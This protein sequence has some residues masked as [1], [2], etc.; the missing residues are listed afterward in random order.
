[1]WFYTAMCVYMYT[2]TCSPPT[3][4]IQR[5]EPSCVRL[6]SQGLCLPG[7]PLRPRIEFRRV[8]SKAW[9][10]GERKACLC[11]F[12]SPAMPDPICPL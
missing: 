8:G 7:S 2:L 11:F 4:W 9:A 3:K 10:K 12:R 6:G 5:S 1:M